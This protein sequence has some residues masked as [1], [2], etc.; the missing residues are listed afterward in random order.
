MGIEE[1]KDGTG[2]QAPNQRKGRKLVIGGGSCIL[3]RGMLSAQFCLHL[4]LFTTLFF[5]GAGMDT[6]RG[7]HAAKSVT[8]FSPQRK[9]S[10]KFKGKPNFA[11]LKAPFRI[12]KSGKKVVKASMIHLRRMVRSPDNSTVMHEG[13]EIMW[14]ICMNANEQDKL[15][16]NGACA[17]VV[18]TLKKHENNATV[19]LSALKLAGNLCFAQVDIFKKKKSALMPR[20]KTW[21]EL[22][23]LAFV[24][25]AEK[26]L[27]HVRVGAR[28]LAE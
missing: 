13:C 3:K 27:R 9:G 1:G 26:S 14:K 20:T 4:S 10:T 16:H 23:F 2:K 25:Q 17:A 11:K 28:L 7:L 6:I 12:A 18:V 24:V 21:R 5:Q 8:S 22:T 19:V 15:G